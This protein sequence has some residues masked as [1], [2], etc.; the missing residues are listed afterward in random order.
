[1]YLLLER[2]RNKN[3]GKSFV[4]NYFINIPH[5]EYQEIKNINKNIA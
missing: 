4:K 2:L 5:H 3:K 1:M